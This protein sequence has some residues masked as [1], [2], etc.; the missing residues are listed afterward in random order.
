MLTSRFSL[1]KVVQLEIP[2]LHRKPRFVAWVK[3][4]VSYLAKIQEDLY[5]L[6]ESSRIEALMTPQ[7]KYLEGILNRRYGR[8]DIFINDG[9][10]LGPWIWPADETADP[11][12][13]LDQ[14]DSYVWS[15]GDSTVI[16]F[17]VNIPAVLDDETSYIAA[18]VNKFKLAGKTFVIQIF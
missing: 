8:T 16:D 18:V 1:F 14:A 12:F 9:F 13:Y 17:V 3:T 2:F 11:V 5:Q 4:F 6:W 7:I 10:D 15:S